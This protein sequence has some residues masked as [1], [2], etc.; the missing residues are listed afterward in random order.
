MRVA[1]I[2]ALLAA[3]SSVMTGSA[4]TPRQRKVYLALGDSVQFGDGASKPSR[5]L[6]PLF[7]QYLDRVDAADQYINLAVPGETSSTMQGGPRS[8]LAQALAVINSPRTDVTVVTLGIGGND[9][10]FDNCLPEPLSQACLAAHQAAMDLLARNLAVILPQL[11]QA[12]ERDPG[13]ERLIMMTYYQPFGGTGLP[14]EDGLDVLWQGR[15]GA[16]NCAASAAQ[17]ANV[18]LND[19]ISCVGMR[20]GAQIVD[21]FTRFDDRALELTH[22][23]D[24]DV[25]PNDAGHALIA[26]AL[27]DAYNG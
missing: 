2:L 26:A 14:F 3:L 25:H 1:L 27:I 18:G 20:Y 7:Y 8:Q 6:A 21:L 4:A 11:T 19:V 5:G 10:P 15:D 23:A 13:A 16:V 24:F 9:V 22:I 12:F 17:P